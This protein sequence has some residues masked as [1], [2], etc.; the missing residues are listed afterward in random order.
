M[1]SAQVTWAIHIEK[2]RE[3]KR[4]REGDEGRW[5]I[6]PWLKTKK[7]ELGRAM[8]EHGE[9]ERDESRGRETASL[10]RR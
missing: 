10:G 1:S 6:R 5:Q 4:D 8:T 2:E 7:R 3:R 9:A